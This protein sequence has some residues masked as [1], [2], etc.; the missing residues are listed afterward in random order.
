MTT[1]M[2]M[3]GP[4]ADRPLIERIRR[5]FQPQTVPIEFVPLPPLDRP[6]PVGHLMDRPKPPGVKDAVATVSNLLLNAEA[7]EERNDLLR[8]WGELSA[9]IETFLV[10]AKEKHSAELRR[11]IDELNVQGRASRDRL[12]LLTAERGRL[13]SRMNVLQE[14]I[15]KAEVKLRT[16][17]ASKPDDDLFPTE[18]ELKEWRRSV[19]SARVAVEREAEPR[20]ELQELIDQNA[21]QRRAEAARL[22][23]IKER[24]E[25]L[26]AALAG[27]PHAGP[28][29]LQV[30][31]A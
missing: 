3:F 11:Q 13:D 23:E 1:R 5:D 19:D 22:K 4:N 29:G 8:E 9:R 28:F 16:T 31:G 18:D 21:A 12:S 7:C 15:G 2:T 26:R 27:R 24:R 17:V 30:P 25:N 6:D 14:Q 10:A 20:A